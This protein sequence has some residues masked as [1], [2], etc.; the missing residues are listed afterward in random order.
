MRGTT[1]AAALALAALSTPLAPPLAQETGTKPIAEPDT[2][3]LSDAIR[4]GLAE[5]EAGEVGAE[6]ASDA[7]VRRFAER[8][9]RDHSPVNERLKAIAAKHRIEPEGTYGTQPMR[10]EEAAAAEM[11]R[12]AA[13]SGAE[14]DRAYMD[15][16]VKDHEKDVALFRAQAKDGKDQELKGLAAAT[17]P[18]LEEHLRMAQALAGQ[19]AS[20]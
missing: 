20:Q 13:M 3:F 17:L 7:E 9:V 19:K 18:T 1:A 11:G 5:V 2:S 4:A 16:M 10:P 12:I 14:F 15:H 6:K 8:M